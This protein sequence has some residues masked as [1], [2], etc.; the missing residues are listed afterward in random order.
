MEL[1]GQ[2]LGVCGDEGVDA[3]G[4]GFELVELVGSKDSNC[5]VG[6]GTELEGALT[7]VVFEERWAE[8]LGEVTG[9]M[10]AEG[11]H[12]PEAVLRG[13]VTLREEK[14]VEVGGADGGNTLWIA[15]DRH[16]RSETRDVDVAVKLWER[17]VHRSAECGRCGDDRD[18]QQ[19][20]EE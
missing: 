8:D 16:G 13:D 11:V 5:P 9:G 17:G 7:A 15:C 3:V 6:C 2:C 12:L 20:G 18:E 4:I 14:V 19:Q 1:D 10:A